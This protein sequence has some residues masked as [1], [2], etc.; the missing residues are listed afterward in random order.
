MKQKI[1]NTDK[2]I[3][4]VEKEKPRDHSESQS[5]EEID[6]IF[7]WLANSY[8]FMPMMD[9]TIVFD[10]LKRIVKTWFLT[11]KEHKNHL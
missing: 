6:G 7:Y 2:G 1:T 11:K 10:E 5:N 8:P 3:E 4:P 9:L